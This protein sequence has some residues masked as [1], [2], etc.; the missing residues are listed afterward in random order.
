M[1]SNDLHAVVRCWY[2]DPFTGM[3]RLHFVS[4]KAL[5]PQKG[6]FMGI[7]A[8]IVLG[9]IAGLVAKF[10]MPGRQGGGIIV[11]TL[12][13]I[14]G[15]FIGGWIGTQLKWGDIS[16]FDMRSLGLAILGAVVILFIY[17][18]ISSRR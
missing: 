4:E 14:V 3:S 12:L 2:N 11:T 6:F 7:L 18:L 13:G 10:L 8:W 1:A 9:F 17:G 16:G 5:M 15:A